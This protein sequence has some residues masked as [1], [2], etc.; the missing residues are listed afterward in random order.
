MIDDVI[1]EIIVDLVG[2]EEIFFVECIEVILFIVDELIGLVVLV[3][4][5]GFLVFVV[6]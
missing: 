6:C 5:V 4:V 1:D 2:V 3:V